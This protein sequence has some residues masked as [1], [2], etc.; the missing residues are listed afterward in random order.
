MKRFC[1]PSTSPP[2]LSPL[3]SPKGVGLAPM[4]PSA[5]RPNKP[6]LFSQQPQACQR[7]ICGGCTLAPCSRNQTFILKTCFRQATP[8]PSWFSQQQY[9]HRVHKADSLENLD[10]MR[11][12]SCITLTVWKQ[13]LHMCASICKAGRQHRP[14]VRVLT[15][16]RAMHA[17]AVLSITLVLQRLSR[18]SSPKSKLQPLIPCHRLLLLAG[19]AG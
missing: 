17:C 11:G 1:F 15:L 3:F 10:D 7:W 13:Q 9:F 5:S 14:N 4:T 19:H 18:G 2:N 16:L 6:R 12:G 8:V